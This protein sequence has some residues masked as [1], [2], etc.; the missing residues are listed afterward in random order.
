MFG[1]LACAGT[2][3]IVDET[4]GSRKNQVRWA[5][6]KVRCILIGDGGD[7][8]DASP[9]HPQSS[10]L[11]FRH[12]Q[13]FTGK[14]PFY[15]NPDQQVIVQLAKG[16][17]PDKPE[18]DQL[19]STMWSL[20][21]KCWDKD[22]KKRPDVAKV[23]KKLDSKDGTSASFIEICWPILKN[24]PE[25]RRYSLLPASVS[26]FFESRINLPFGEGS[27]TAH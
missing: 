20:T 22:P 17:R 7:R 13:I 8:G 10:L 12:L 18:H 11:T 24:V 1:P 25:K 14:H 4:E 19:T 9:P 21:R 3:C 2:S 26:T 16:S 27:N 5:H 6:R 15:P 23:L